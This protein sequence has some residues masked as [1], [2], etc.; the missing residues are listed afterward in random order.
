MIAEDRLIVLAEKDTLLLS[1]P[2]TLKGINEIHF[3]FRLGKEGLAMINEALEAKPGLKL[4]VSGYYQ[5]M[6]NLDWSLLHQVRHLTLTEFGIFGNPVNFNSLNKLETLSLS[7]NGLIDPNFR[8][9]NL[10]ALQSLSLFSNH[11][12]A[13]ALQDSFLGLEAASGLLELKLVGFRPFDDRLANHFLS[14]LIHLKELR[15]SGLPRLNKL[16]FVRK[17]DSLTCIHLY[18]LKNIRFLAPLFELPGLKELRCKGLKLKESE[19]VLME[20]L[21]QCQWEEVVFDY[22]EEGER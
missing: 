21:P 13:N 20:K 8:P 16:D 14:N 4:M 1:Q 17:M 6:E 10:P 9:G 5:S 11:F 2:E 3:N 18:N 7:Q 12:A 15:L 22:L 19:A